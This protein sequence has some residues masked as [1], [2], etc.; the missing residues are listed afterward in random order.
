LN[1]TLAALECAGYRQFIGG[2]DV[3]PG[4]PRY[5]LRTCHCRHTIRAVTR[6]QQEI[7]EA[8]EQEFLC[9]G[10][11]R[12]FKVLSVALQQNTIR[13]AVMAQKDGGKLDQMLEGGSATW[14]NWG[15]PVVSVSVDEGHIYTRKVDAPVPVAGAVITVRP[16]RFLEALL[17]LWKRDDLANKCFSWAAEALIGHGCSSLDVSPS[18]HELRDRQ[19]S[20]YK[21]LSHK[22]GFLWGPPGTGKTTTAAAIA[23]D[24]VM[25]APNARVLLVAP[26]NSAA[27]QLL[28]GTDKHLSRSLSGQAARA[29]CARLGSNFVASH[30]EGRQ[31]LLPQATEDLLS[32]K[33]KLEAAKTTEDPEAI[34]LWQQEMEGI[35]SA[36]RSEVETTLQR[37]RVVAMTAIFATMHYKALRENTVFDLIIFDE[38]SQLGRAVALMLAALGRQIL[39]AGDPRQLAPIFGSKHAFVKRWFGRTLFDEYMDEQHAST[40]L[41]NEQSRMAEPICSLVGKMFYG[42]ELKVCQDCLR[43]DDWNSY[44]R[45]TRFSHTQPASNLH[46]FRVTTDGKPH[47]GSQQRTESAEMAVGIAQQLGTQVDH[48]QIVILTPFVAQRRLI[49]NLLKARGMRRVRVCTVHSAQGAEKHTVIFDPVKGSSPFLLH[50]SDG[51]RL[52]NVAISRAQSCFVLL[53][54]ENDLKHPILSAVAESIAGKD[55]FT[56]RS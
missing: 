29:D 35:F 47:G 26:T 3:A 46:L 37:K 44:R 9:S 10:K 6:Q 16:L 36:L 18:F 52:I 2:K 51:R 27:D 31:H 11:E 40:C 1:P 12:K 8:I 15:S 13:I 41:L 54:S 14:G 39:I 43:H 30:Y 28:V 34:A 25:S 55:T 17:A 4:F 5:A 48:A 53:A 56:L 20:A 49:H 21:L 38:A 33:A 24:F 19:R 22:A 32:R 7:V 23:A 42:G 45:P 50:P